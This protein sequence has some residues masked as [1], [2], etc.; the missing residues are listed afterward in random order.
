MTSRALAARGAATL[1]RCYIGPCVGVVFGVGCLDVE[2]VYYMKVG[3]SL[4]GRLL[5]CHI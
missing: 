1:G 2:R 4:F 5:C 3:G